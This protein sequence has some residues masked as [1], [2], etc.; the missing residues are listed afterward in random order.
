MKSRCHSQFSSRCCDSRSRVIRIHR[1]SWE[2]DV[3]HSHIS[4]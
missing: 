4:S 1:H 2:H 3:S